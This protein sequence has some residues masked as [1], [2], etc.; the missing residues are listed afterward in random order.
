M[1]SGSFLSTQDESGV[2]A[3]ADVRDT[4]VSAPRPAGAASL[5]EVQF[6][7]RVILV[8]ALHLH[9]DLNGLPG[10]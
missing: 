1:K 5:S 3:G 4:H 2:S 8:A 10:H 6:E 9:T 7:D